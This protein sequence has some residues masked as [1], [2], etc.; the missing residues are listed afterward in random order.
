MKNLTKKFCEFPPRPARLVPCQVLDK[1]TWPDPTRVWPTNLRKY[2][3]S[4]LHCR[5]RL[6]KRNLNV[7]RKT[8]L[9]GS[10]FDSQ[11]EGRRFESS[12]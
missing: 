6:R 1:K 2:S 12:L 7:V 8:G 4:A 3:E 10:K 11:S 5:K 9:V